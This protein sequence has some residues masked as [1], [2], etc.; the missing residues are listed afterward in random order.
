MAGIILALPIVT[1]KVEAWRRFCQEM[2]G[3]RKSEHDNSRLRQGITREC[4]ALVET[5]YG[6]AAVTAFE[7]G[8]VS[9]ALSGILTS[10]LPF[11]HWYR[12]QV[13]FLHGITLASYEQFSLPTPL[14]DHHELLFD[15]VRPATAIPAIP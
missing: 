3:S 2:A 12:T 15:W 13:Q 8:D 14:P 7:A 9:Q 6:S 10:S 1:G 5:P 4:M 11:D